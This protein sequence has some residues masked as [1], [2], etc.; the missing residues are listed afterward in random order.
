MNKIVY[1]LW[2]SIFF[3]TPYTSTQ[4]TVS[5][6]F[7]DIEISEPLLSELIE[8]PTMQRLKDIHQYGISYWAGS[9]DYVYSRFDHSL[10]V[11]HLVRMFGGS[12]HEQ[13]AALLHD[14][15]HTVFSHVGD[16]LFSAYTSQSLIA[17]DSSYQDNIHFWFLQQTEIPD[18]LNR[19]GIA[20]QDILHKKHGFTMLEQELPRLC[21]D[22]LE[23]L[24]H[25]GLYEGIFTHQ[26]IYS[27]IEQLS[28]RDDSW[29][30]NTLE[31]ALKVGYASLYLTEN[32][33]CSKENFV[34]YDLAAQA[35]ARAL[36]IQ[37]I[38]MKDIHF[39][40]DYIIWQKLCSS[41]DETLSILLD[42]LIHASN[43][44]YITQKSLLNNAHVYGKFRGV[45]PLV[46]T[47]K[48]LTSARALNQEFKNSFEQLKTRI[49]HGYYIKQI[50]YRAAPLTHTIRGH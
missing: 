28:F 7:G 11:F 17:E 32:L 37:L 8:C 31:S 21:A 30:F 4:H 45:D 2:V 12:I 26:D 19:H 3:I 48:G 43:Y 13:I 50:S 33:F 36:D 49:K 40:T 5:S 41:E 47:K 22:R 9:V 46:R 20:T 10:G 16:H 39:G 23:Y 1:S 24:L 14:V 44:Y 25:G 27:I 34:Q 6:I 42:S 38:H 18:I 29:I 35:L 15:S